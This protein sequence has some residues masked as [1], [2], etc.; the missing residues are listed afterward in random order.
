MN[1]LPEGY[2]RLE[3]RALGAR[4]LPVR[5]VA[6]DEARLWFGGG[7][8]GASGIASVRALRWARVGHPVL[9]PIVDYG[10]GRSEVPWYATP[11]VEE[12]GALALHEVIAAMQ[13]LCALHGAGI[14]HGDLRHG[15]VRLDGQVA[16]L[17]PWPD[18]PGVDDRDAMAEH[19]WAAVA[20]GVPDK[21]ARSLTLRVAAPRCVAGAIA[22]L[23]QGRGLLVDA[24]LA[25]VEGGELGS[26][27][28]EL[29][30]TPLA[31][32]VAL[33]ADEAPLA[34]PSPLPTLP[35]LRARREVAVVAE[36]V[37]TRLWSVVRDV[38]STGR[39]RILVLEGRRAHLAGVTAWL[40]QTLAKEAL[41]ESLA[42]RGGRSVDLARALHPGGDT[43]EAFEAAWRRAAPEA[44]DE[45]VVRARRWC[46]PLAEGER[47]ASAAVGRRELQRRIDGGCARGLFLLT[48]DEVGLD[49]LALAADLVRGDRPVVV[50]ATVEADALAAN[51]ALT[52]GIEALRAPR[53]QVDGADHDALE[54]WVAATELA[55]DA[56]A[57]ARD[58]GGEPRRLRAWLQH[59]ADSGR[60]AVACE[61]SDVMESLTHVVGEARRVRDALHLAALSELPVAVADGFLGPAQ[62]LWGITALAERIGGVVLVEPAIAADARR[63][64]DHAYLQR[65]LSR[66]WARS[67]DVEAPLRAAEHA[68]EAGDLPFA[69]S[70]WER[71]ALE[72]EAAR[73]GAALLAACDGIAEHLEEAS[74]GPL[75]AE[76]RAV[77]LGWLG[78]DA[79]GAWEQALAQADTAAA[80]A[81]AR[82]G[83]ARARQAAG[84]DGVYDA[85]EAAAR[86]ASEASERHA[87]AMALLG[88]GLLLAVEHPGAAQQKFHRALHRLGSD[89]APWRVATVLE[90]QAREQARVG[91]MNQAA[92]LYGDAEEA[93]LEADDGEAAARCALGQAMAC[94]ERE[95]L[96]DAMAAADR[97]QAVARAWLDPRGVVRAVGV[98]ARIERQA[99]SGA[100]VSLY[101]RAVR[102]AGDLGLHDVVVEAHLGLSMLA[103][104]QGDQHAAYEATSAAAAALEALPG[105]PLWARYRLAVAAQL[106]KRGDHTQC[107]QWLWSAKELGLE[108]A[109]RDVA[110]LAHDI[111]EMAKEEGWG[112]VIR[113]AGDIAVQQLQRLGNKGDADRLRS[114]ITGFINQ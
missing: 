28:E 61:P 30:L 33:P 58:S 51:D 98:R 19:L 17:P 68:R 25:L 64:A 105:H 85:L 89:A 8:P 35:S 97:G 99:G 49:G 41:A 24:L 2:E 67:S 44:T 88:Q 47:R 6:D 10:G 84:A 104:A 36:V 42:L 66:A 63:R 20:D 113:V 77:A 91:S 59:G 56:A 7:P 78:R 108:V 14:R 65:R 52:A 21:Q 109:H 11:M 90:A 23:W 106:A 34:P 92:E 57:V 80:M 4:G 112:N 95:R 70:S 50:V 72:A 101:D 9:V 29:P 60:P 37:R 45:E 73:D 76:R 15:L 110:S 43:V 82:V 96:E 53:V 16:L 22:M 111:C 102:D 18:E 100:A 86:A 40:R 13:G 26:P 32:A 81:R 114:D 74:D 93:W 3:D 1:E 46:G 62:G 94:I 39:P 54:A 103:L 83:L 69:R 75:W 79:Q 12:A 27:G 71:G 87:E 55:A 31:P 5:H 107:W 38:A 48:I